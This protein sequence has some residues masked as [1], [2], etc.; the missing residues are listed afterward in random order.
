MFSKKNL[1]EKKDIIPCKLEN[2]RKICDLHHTVLGVPGMFVFLH[3][4]VKSHSLVFVKSTRSDSILKWTKSLNNVYKQ[5]LSVTTFLTKIIYE[6]YWTVCSRV[7]SVHICYT[8]KLMPPLILYRCTYWPSLFRESRKQVF[9]QKATY[10][11]CTQNGQIWTK[12]WPFWA[13]QI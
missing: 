12:F 4:L 7:L 6:Q 10:P 13:Q 11:Y 3:I 5:T 8:E 1:S 2:P 9:Y